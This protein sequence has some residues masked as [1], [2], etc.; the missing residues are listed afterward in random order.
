MGVSCFCGKFSENKGDQCLGS[1]QPFKIQEDFA[2]RS[3]GKELRRLV[4][5]SRDLSWDKVART[6]AVQSGAD[7]VLHNR[8]TIIKAS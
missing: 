8:L 4:P 3:S 6:E 5:W 1:R 2:L 7:L